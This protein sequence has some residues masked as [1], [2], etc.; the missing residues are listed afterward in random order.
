[1]LFKPESVDVDKHRDMLIGL[2]LPAILNEFPDVE[3]NR[4]DHIIIQQDGAPS[5]VNP[6]NCFWMETLTEMGLE[7]KIKLIT[8]PAKSPD[9]NINDLGFFNA[10]QAMHCCTTPRNAVQ[11]I[12]MVEQTHKKH[13]VNKINRIW[14]TL[15]A[16]VS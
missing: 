3:C 14:L 10:L 11:L 15:Q 1:V 16:E 4:C 12:D 13:P 5:H 6:H 8:Q 2:V 7:D 9:L